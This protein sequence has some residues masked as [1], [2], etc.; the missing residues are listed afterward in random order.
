MKEPH[1]G[2]QIVSSQ[3]Y[4]GLVEGIQMGGSKNFHFMLQL[5]FEMKGT[6]KKHQLGITQILLEILKSPIA[7][8]SKTGLRGFLQKNID[9]TSLKSQQWILKGSLQLLVQDLEICNAIEK[10]EVRVREVFSQNGPL[11]LISLSFI[12]M[13]S[14]QCKNDDA[15]KIVAKAWGK[16]T[17]SRPWLGTPFLFGVVTLTWDNGTSFQKEILIVL[18]G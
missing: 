12:V 9:L 13:L 18:M 11:I 7:Y 17:W 1:Y 5:T 16:T 4:C 8:G 3:L 15:S 14:F 6:E 10:L 2:I